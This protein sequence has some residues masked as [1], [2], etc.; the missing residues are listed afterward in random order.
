MLQQIGHMHFYRPTA[1][2]RADDIVAWR[3]MV[4]TRSAVLILVTEVQ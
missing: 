4:A 2:R 1:R 3:P